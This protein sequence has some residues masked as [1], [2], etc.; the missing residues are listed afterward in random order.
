[1]RTWET[2][3][4]SAEQKGEA[5]LDK[6]FWELPWWADSPELQECLRGAVRKA[7]QG[8][9][10]RCEAHFQ[11]AEGKTK[12]VDLSLTPMKDDSGKVVL[13]VPEAREITETKQAE[14]VLRESERKLGLIFDK[15]PFAIALAKLPEGVIAD[16]N[17]AWVKTFG[18]SKEEA[19]GKTSLELGINRDPEGRTRLYAEVQQRGSVR[20]WKYLAS[21]NPVL[22]SSSSPM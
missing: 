15:A 2:Y 9:A 8:E 21:R 17:E 4:T 11:T 6:P 3:F 1:M 19:V 20:T 10:V 16:V 13:L 22:Q 7:G 12:W 18:Y 14:E 5:L